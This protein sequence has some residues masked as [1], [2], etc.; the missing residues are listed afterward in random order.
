MRGPRARQ[1]PSLARANGNHALS[2]RFS[3][4]RRGFGFRGV[5][6]CVVVE[7]IKK[8]PARGV[9]VRVRI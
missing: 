9:R 4:S 5:V 6:E 2:N 1:F 7:V 3:E 8:G